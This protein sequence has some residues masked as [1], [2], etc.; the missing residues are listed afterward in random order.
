MI[1]DTGLK[2]D[3]VTNKGTG[4]SFNTVA[5]ALK[6]NSIG[7]KSVQDGT[8]TP[9]AKVDIESVDLQ[10]VKAT[11]K[12]LL[13][14]NATSKTMGGMSFTVKNGNVTV[15]GTSTTTI[16]YPID[17]GMF[18]DKVPIPKWLKKGKE[19][20][21]SS[22]PNVII[23][24]FKADGTYYNYSNQK[25]TVPDDAIYYGVH[26]R[27]NS[28]VTMTNK[29]FYPM[30]RPASITDDTYETY[31]ENSFTLSN[32]ITLRSIGKV[33]DIICKQG[34]VWG[35][36]R[37]VGVYTPT[38]NETYSLSGTG[39]FAWLS[40][41]SVP[42]HPTNKDG[43]S[44]HFTMATSGQ[45]TNAQVDNGFYYANS[46]NFRIKGLTTADEYKNYFTNN[47]VSFYYV[48]AEPVF[49]PLPDADQNVFNSLSSYDGV[50]VIT[51]DSSIEPEI[52]V[53]NAVSLT[54]AYVLESDRALG[55]CYFKR[56]GDKFYIGYN[57]GTS[58]TETEV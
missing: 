24:F 16:Y 10:V 58:V 25:F 9:D 33:K 23:Y 14:N 11:G 52:C 36:I 47:S 42:I 37:R 54:G 4:L 27:F 46:I 5:S 12:N 44:T 1:F 41:S 26:I 21:I 31:K 35:V 51:T 13:P 38:G 15:N 40:G 7:G 3:V 49:E 45:L 30:I 56:E 6:I 22:T 57:D 2:S 43:Y 39:N 32:K 8:P 20:I 19:Y 53:T 29:T 50:T 55:G 28:G 17:G 18:G 34:N 48:L